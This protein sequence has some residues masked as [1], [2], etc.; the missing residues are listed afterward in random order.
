MCYHTVVTR[1]SGGVAMSRELHNQFFQS[2]P[3]SVSATKPSAEPQTSP[4]VIERMRDYEHKFNLISRR[5]REYSKQLE[6]MDRRMN[7]QIQGS[8]SRFER[9]QSLLGRM[10]QFLKNTTQESKA[11]ISTLAGKMTERRAMDAK[12]EELIDRHNQLVQSF[13]IKMTQMQKVISEQELK[14]MNY[15]SKL[16]NL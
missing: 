16:R 15:E 14:L 13:E 5:M 7:E 9:M 10:E 6:T 2:S 3:E 4:V 11:R 8:Q 1:K 12:I